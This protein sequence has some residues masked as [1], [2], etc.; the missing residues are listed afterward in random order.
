MSSPVGLGFGAR[1]LLDAHQR[2]MQEGLPVYLRIQNSDDSAQAYADVGF[3]V[4]VTGSLATG[5][6]TTDIKI[7]PPPSVQAL[8]LHEIG[9]MGWQQLQF[10]ATRF[11]ISHTWVLEQMD[12]QHYTNPYSVFRDPKRVI[13]IVYNEQ[14]YT[15]ES[16]TPEEMGGTTL[17]W[18]IVC[19]A[20]QLNVTG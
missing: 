8:D 9:I 4:A 19:N 12:A 15:I 1:F 6:G 2:F 11:L 5:A 7:S 20:P 10:G 13:G 14:L 17:Y 16:I 18:N 3:E